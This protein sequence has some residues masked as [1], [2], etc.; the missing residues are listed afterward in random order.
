MVRTFALGACVAATL[1]CLA[2]DTT[3][4]VG[5][6]LIT[7]DTTRADRLT[8]YG[9]MGAAMPHLDRLAREGVVFDRAS[10]VA[11]LT[12]PAHAS[13]FTGLLPSSHGVRENDSPP[14][15]PQHMT[16]AE[17]L[18]AHGFITA[19]VVGSGVLDP[20]RGLFQGFEHYSSVPATQRR[21]P[22]TGQRTAKAVVNEAISWLNRTAN[23]RFFLWAHLYDP[24]RPYEPPEPFASRYAGDPYVGEIAYADSQ[25]GRLVEAL[26]RSRLL[27]KSIVIVAGDHGESLGEHGERD[28][29][30][31]VYESVL[32]VP[33]IIRGPE[34]EP[35]RI[36]SVVRLVDVMP[37]I[38]DLLDQPQL[39]TDGVSLDAVMR[40]QPQDL[41]AYA[42]SIYPL[43]FG[44]SPIRSLR[45]GRFKLI[46]APRPELYDLERD[47]F[48]QTNV[49]TDR[50]TTAAALSRRLTAL[51]GGRSWSESAVSRQAA[52][53]PEVR[54]R[55]A[56]VGYVSSPP[57]Q[58][59]RAHRQDAKDF[60]V[61]NWVPDRQMNKGLGRASGSGT[62]DVR[63]QKGSKPCARSFVPRAS[64]PS[65]SS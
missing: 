61:E 28:H 3:A 38:L 36:S 13:L 20:D 18:R 8:P 30:I 6:V 29:G 32:R 17:T 40:G 35:R 52:P 22:Q 4:P 34:I 5:V 37:T 21:G 14:L 2:R 55:L 59:E 43:R 46:D 23:S 7:L 51:A 62:V 60:V 16:L 44:W 49:Y 10:S 63:G 12:V 48:E 25:I 19:A 54:E 47:P 53:P 1:S 9:F 26:E 31:F 24:H 41:E 56:A 57:S 39:L 33:L 58:T 50:P 65:C 27:D 11:P 45:D 42:E 64:L 15:S